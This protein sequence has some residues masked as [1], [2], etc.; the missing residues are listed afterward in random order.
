MTKRVILPNAWEEE[1]LV[2]IVP[3]GNYANH[4]KTKLAINI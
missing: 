2:S 1:L 3:T 4:L